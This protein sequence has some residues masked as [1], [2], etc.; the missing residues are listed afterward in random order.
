MIR[1]PK[2]VSKAAL[3]TALAAAVPL[4]PA[5]AQTP[6]TS[7]NQP[8]V[9]PPNTEEDDVY[10]APKVGVPAGRIS[11][12]TRG[13]HPLTTTNANENKTQTAGA[14]STATGASTAKPLTGAATPTSH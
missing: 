5:S 1:T 13:I 2:F 8:V 4:S 3:A 10:Q 9:A 12:G 6:K 11:G 7:A 14:A